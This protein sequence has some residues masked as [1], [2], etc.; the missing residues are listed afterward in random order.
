[1]ASTR[2]GATVVLETSKEMVFRGGALVCV[3]D[4]IFVR[5]DYGKLGDLI[6]FKFLEWTR[7]SIEFLVVLLWMVW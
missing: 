2:R 4:G 3:R 6:P 7:G 5:D 1:M